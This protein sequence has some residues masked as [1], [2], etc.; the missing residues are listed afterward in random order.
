MEIIFAVLALSSLDAEEF[1]SEHLAETRKYVIKKAAALAFLAFILLAYCLPLII[2]AAQTSFI[3]IRVDF[4]GWLFWGG[5]FAII[6]G[7]ICATANVILDKTMENKGVYTIDESTARRRHLSKIRFISPLPK[8]AKVFVPLIAVTV[9]MHI[10]CLNIFTYEFFLRGKGK[11]WTD[12]NAFVEYMEERV[13]ENG[14]SDEDNYY[15]V[16]PKYSIWF[17]ASDKIFQISFRWNNRTVEDFNINGVSARNV[18]RGHNGT[19]YTQIYPD[20]VTEPNLP[21]NTYDIPGFHAITYSCE[22]AFDARDWA[23][24]IHTGFVL[25][26][27]AEAIALAVTYALMVAKK[28]K[29]TE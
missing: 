1:D 21:Q 4:T 20:G 2:D 18:E 19:V 17:E 11:E 14:A 8:L 7:I 16:Y 22:E 5:L 26:Y 28:F 6:A 27:I 3:N 29:E 13:T 23:Y 9:A 15:T 25:A 12:A 10:V 24:D